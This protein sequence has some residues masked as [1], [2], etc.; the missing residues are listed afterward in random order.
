[1]SRSF[2]EPDIDQVK[3]LLR[4]MVG[5]RVVVVGDMMLDAYLMGRISR[6]SPEA[7]VPVFEIQ[8]HQFTLGGAA[9]VAKCL[10]ALGAK[11]TVCGVLGADADAD[12][13]RAEA[14]SLN[15][16]TAGLVADASRPTTLKS[17]VV[18]R[19]QQL[20]RLD[21][22]A[23]R[24]VTP[25]VVRRLV[26]RI[27]KAVAR[28]EAVVLSD[29]GKGVLTPA[30]CR[31]AI[32]SAA[33]PPANSRTR[34]NRAPSKPVVVD[35][36]GLPWDCYRGATM[37][38]PNQHEASAFGGQTMDD[39]VQA[40]RIARA[41]LAKVQ[42]G[43]ALV[44]RGGQGMT[45]ASAGKGR[46]NRVLHL[47][48]IRREVFDGTGAGDVV[49]TTVAL[50]LAAGA[51]AQTSAFLA[52]IAGSI[53]V[54]K[55]GAAVVTDS[56]ILQALSGGPMR[57]ERKVME[58]EQAAGLAAQ[59]RHR[60]KRVVFT[61]GCFDILHVGHVHYLEQS[62]RMGDALIVG[63]N[64]D[65]SVRRLKKGHGRPVQHER[66]RAQ[67]VAS[68][69]CVNAVVLFNEDTPLALIKAV[70]PDVLT[71]GSDYKRKQDV[72]GWQWVE[73]NGGRVELID[74]VKGRSTTKLLRK[75]SG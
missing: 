32:R 7:P 9:N 74:L 55:F 50:A 6:I 4:A 43:H 28:A 41:I 38:K 14:R 44:T 71:K 72:V 21:R 61:N 29:Y 66:D 36:K 57:Y 26:Q 23:H 10:V 64:T 5:R 49:A 11:V 47:P 16:N 37:I 3:A 22:E 30:V 51:D 33:G 58:R 24:P 63:I 48:P 35:P 27:K 70:R 13:V 42:V 19:H 45:L 40:A 60:S 25:A 75:V 56:E 18:A 12:L 59:L 8:S 17:R 68:Q 1:M 67:I 34:A 62:R 53:A 69:G 65:A 31:A 73:R 46:L 2:T 15:I 39:D 20:M 52:N 54:S